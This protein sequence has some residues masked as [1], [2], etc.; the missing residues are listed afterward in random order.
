MMP[1]PGIFFVSASFFNSFS[2][3]IKW[4][5]EGFNSVS[6][7]RVGLWSVSRVSFRPVRPGPRPR[8]PGPRSRS[9]LKLNHPLAAESSWRGG[10]SLGSV[11]CGPAGEQTAGGALRLKHPG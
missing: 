5:A 3:T 6:R 8:R 7:A 9:S 1:A 10:A 11:G 4:G 2:H